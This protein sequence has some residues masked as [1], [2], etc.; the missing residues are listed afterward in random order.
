MDPLR[1]RLIRIAAS[2]PPGPDRNAILDVITANRVAMEHPSA[3]A[4]RDYLREHPNA[5]P[6]NHTV[7]KDTGGGGSKSKAQD[8]FDKALG[9]RM[10]RALKELPEGKLQDAG[11]HYLQMYRRHLTD[12][13]DKGNSAANT[14]EALEGN[15]D[16]F[17][18]KKD[19]E[20]V[21]DVVQWG[22]DA[23]EAEDK[24]TKARTKAIDKGFNS[25]VESV[26]KPLRSA[27]EHYLSMHKNHL[28]GEKGGQD[29]ANTMEIL[30]GN[31]ES[32]DRKEDY[33]AVHKAVGKGLDAMGKAHKENS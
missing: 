25:A 14:M 27:V 17:D 31:S 7:K 9:A 10:D 18:S 20:Q 33:E 15:A 3:E 32:F 29:A 4:R 16:R 30:E 12:A 19:F 11:R 1:R 6:K 28:M 8:V 24:R 21:R 13:G 22:I 26:P 23:M 5:D 2:F